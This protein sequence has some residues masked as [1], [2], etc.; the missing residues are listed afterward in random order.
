MV[1]NGYLLESELNNANS[2]FSKWGFAR[3]GTNEYFLKEL[4]TPVYPINE[5][6]MS[7]ELFESKRKYCEDYEKHFKAYYEAINNASHGN[8]VRVVEFFRNESKYYVVTEKVVTK[9]MLDNEVTSLPI[10][11]KVLLLRTVAYCFCDLHSAGIIHFDVKPN[12]LLIKKTNSGGYAAKLID[13]DSGFFKGKKIDSDEICGD[14]TY[15]A[16]ETFLAILGEDV[17]PDEKV[18][19]FSLGLVFHEFMCGKLP[20]YNTNEYDYPYEAAL[21][22]GKLDPD[23]SIL[24][25]ELK[26]VIASMLDADPANRPTAKEVFEKLSDMSGVSRFI[27]TMNKST[28]TDDSFDRLSFY[29][30]TS[31][32]TVSVTRDTT[33]APQ[34]DSDGWFSSAGDL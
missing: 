29:N 22:N 17:I 13:F 11:K 8:L 2:G 30:T 14:L 32:S 3:K 1:I 7:P 15:L 5:N 25:I 20:D 19:I 23:D 24:P 31:S 6:S 33:P 4:L 10:N 21:D 18:D 28:A 34:K 16:P 26:H 9:S 27:S 12:N